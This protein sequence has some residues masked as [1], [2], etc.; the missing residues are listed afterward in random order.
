MKKIILF[1]IACFALLAAAVWITAPKAVQQLEAK[2]QSSLAQSGA[3]LTYR[4][5]KP[6]FSGGWTAMVQG[7]EF[8]FND[9]GREV[10]FVSDSIKISMPVLFF[11]GGRAVISEIAADNPRIDLRL[12]EPGMNPN[13]NATD[14]GRVNPENK[15]AAPLP[16]RIQKIRIQNGE[17]NCRLKNGRNAVIQQINAAVTDPLIEKRLS[18]NGNFKIFGKNPNV[19]FDIAVTRSSSGE[20]MMHHSELKADLSDMNEASLFS[21]F[22]GQTSMPFSELGGELSWSVK[23]I[24][25][26]PGVWEQADYEAE[27]KDASVVFKN[28]PE[29][30]QNADLTV[31]QEGRTL[32]V[33]VEHA[34]WAGGTMS[35]DFRQTP[36]GSES[37]ALKDV[38]LA[39]QSDGIR[40]ER[41]S[42]PKGP[43]TPYVSGLFFAGFQGSG[44]IRT[45][46]E[47]PYAVV[48]DGMAALD[49]GIIQNLNILRTIFDRL[50]SVPSVGASIT[51]AIPPK[52]Q[53]TLNRGYT[54][55]ARA[56]F[57]V[58]YQAGKLYLNQVPL[59]SEGFSAS[60]SGYVDIAGN[61]FFRTYLS[62]DD[63]LTWNMMQA[64]PALQYIVSESGKLGL[65]VDIFGSSRGIQ[66][67]VDLQPLLSRAVQQVG[68][69]LLSQALKRF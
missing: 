67:K 65:G 43:Y 23:Q 61:L 3:K 35:L 41:V 68:S 28:H 57:P 27:I 15:S 47:L 14:S 29:P 9:S 2:L 44:R 12:Y 31:V 4:S 62:L 19:S 33:K 11:S 42:P 20:L 56:E 48:G 59:I 49:Q 58:H 46:E 50:A 17:V 45:L 55:F 60:A 18:V 21:I 69:E 34:S 30:V 40:I 64:A 1:I 66:L 25:L 8:T 7:P 22:T 51:S 38:K 5:I 63:E 54:S 52:Y 10:K 53:N 24:P 39:F 6:G 13:F 16:V 32:G 37:S 36:S 26:N